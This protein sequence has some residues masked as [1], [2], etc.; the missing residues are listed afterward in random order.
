MKSATPILLVEDDRV[1]CMR[2]KRALKDL[3]IVNTLRIA[4]DGVE[5]LEF[6][7]DPRN[8]KPCLILLDM[9]M[10][11]MG[12]IEFLREAKAR[13]EI[14]SIPVIVLTGSTADKDR[15]ESFYLGVAGYMIKPSSY[16]Q[17]LEM[18]RTI[19]LYWTMS[20]LPG[21]GKTDGI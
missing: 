9:N 4:S 11:R 19:D 20:E 6:L 2:V 21:G 16:G 10:P 17:F 14:R 8:D 7:M 1:D 13:E 3:S 18:I 15:V 5:A 12:G